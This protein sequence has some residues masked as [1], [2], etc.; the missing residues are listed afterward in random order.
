MLDAFPSRQ[1]RRRLQGLAVGKH[2]SSLLPCTPSSIS[3]SLSLQV[4]ASIAY[5]LTA[6][7]VSDR[8]QFASNWA[9]IAGSLVIAIPAVLLIK[10]PTAEELA[11][12]ETPHEKEVER[13]EHEHGLD[14]Q[15]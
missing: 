7:N 6:D 3:D 5:K 4:G 15:Q 14:R 12:G 1:A 8:V 13:E 9:L 11:G 2:P 10:E